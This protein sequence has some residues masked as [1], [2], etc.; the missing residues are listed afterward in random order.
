MKKDQNMFIKLVAFLVLALCIPSVQADSPLKEIG[1][2]L[3]G[4]WT[5]EG[6]WASDYPGVGVKGE[7]FT[8]TVSCRWSAGQMAF[9]CEGGDGRVSWSNFYWW[10]A[11]SN[12]VRYI[13]ANS[14]GS[15]EMGTITIQGKKH[16]WAS[17]GT[18]ADGR[19]VEYSGETLFEDTGD[20]RIDIGANVIDGVRSAFRDTY[21]R[22]EE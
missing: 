10:D 18:L 3:V 7:P 16:V 19:P 17:A 4:N 11:G 9:V 22:V 2:Q 5:E 12:Q 6:I 8:I 15:S 14:G 1:D 21:K 13:G 20:T